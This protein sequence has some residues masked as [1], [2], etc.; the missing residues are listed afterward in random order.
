MATAWDKTVTSGRAA[1]TSLRSKLQSS[2]PS[3]GGDG[4]RSLSPPR[5]RRPSAAAAVGAAAAASL[6]P[7]TS[8]WASEL[9]VAKAGPL[10]VDRELLELAK[11][12]L[13]ALV[14]GGTSAVRHFTLLLPD[15]S[16]AR[17]QAPPPA[18]TSSNELH[19]RPRAR[20][21]EAAT[22]ACYPFRGVW[23]AQPL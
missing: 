4:S 11:A 15:V 9:V 23:R 18:S 22:E 2:A 19:A 13:R 8:S 21:R 7:P 6:Y 17:P 14:A 20:V 5:G 10:W 12:P 1:V 3:G 16:S